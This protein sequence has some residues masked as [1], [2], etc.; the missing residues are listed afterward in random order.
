MVGL[1]GPNGS[2]KTTLLMAINGLLPLESGS[3]TLDGTQVA[4]LRPKARAKRM[5]CVPQRPEAIPDLPVADLVLMGRFAHRPFWSG[6]SATDRC[7]AEKALEAAGIAHLRDRS[8]RTL[9]GGEFQ[10]VLT[11]RA[12]SQGSPTLLLDEPAT[13]LDAA[14][15]TAVFSLIRRRNQF[16]GCRVLAA[17]HDLNL[18][19]LFC[20]RLVFLKNGRVHAD[21][22]T[23]AVFTAAVLEAVYETSF[24]VIPHP[25]CGAPQALYSLESAHA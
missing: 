3:I 21:G 7:C 23:A 8:A 6:Y 10:R 25:D 12:L 14:H 13:G 5:A 9:S 4:E 16:D 19:A 17:I 22:P 15:A 20:D 2:G 1:L 24:T 18:A 11:A